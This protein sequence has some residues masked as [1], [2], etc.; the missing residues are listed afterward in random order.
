[1]IELRARI[2][3]ISDKIKNT[4]FVTN[5]FCYLSRKETDSRLSRNFFNYFGIRIIKNSADSY[6]ELL[7]KHG[8]HVRMC[9]FLGLDLLI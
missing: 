6:S 1:M 5:S 9:N 7:I 8:K 4:L 3:F 2:F